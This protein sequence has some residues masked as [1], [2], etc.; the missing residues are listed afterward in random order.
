ME[1]KK[2]Q[3]YSYIRKRVASK[4]GEKQYY[5]YELRIPSAIVEAHQLDK[6]VGKKVKVIIEIES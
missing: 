3:F 2:I 4:R 5:V 6:H 1:E